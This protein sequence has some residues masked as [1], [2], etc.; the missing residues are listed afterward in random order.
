[1]SLPHA[2]V[3]LDTDV[4]VD[5]LRGLPAAGRYVDGLAEVPTASEVTRVE[6][7]RGV[8]SHERRMTERFLATIRWAAVDGDISGLAGELGRRYRRS[9]G[10]I[11][12]ADLVVAATAERLRL[13]LATLNVRHFPMFEGLEP[14]YRR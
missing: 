8:R 10:N 6:V 1:V 4:L 13:P 14:A 9:H 2:S 3:V 11:G 5:Y 12:V 7:L